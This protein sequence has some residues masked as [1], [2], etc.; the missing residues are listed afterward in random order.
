LIGFWASVKA[1]EPIASQ[2]I[3]EDLI[4][5][6]LVFEDRGI[7]HQG[8]VTWGVSS[9]RWGDIRQRLVSSSPLWRQPCHSHVHE[10]GSHCVSGVEPPKGIGV[11]VADMNQVHN[12]IITVLKGS[13]EVCEDIQAVIPGPGCFDG[14]KM[15]PFCRKGVESPRS[16]ER[17]QLIE[18][19]YRFYR[20]PHN[21]LHCSL[22]QDV[23]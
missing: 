22:S 16:Q 15:A 23:T 7:E 18:L 21:M 2:S 10:E 19:S 17:T 4:W 8:V 6:P 20:H 11:F 9:I 12:S 1:S 14:R 5:V 3:A 13:P